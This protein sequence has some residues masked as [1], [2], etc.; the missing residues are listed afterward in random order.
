MLG[1]FLYTIGINIPILT[2][3][4]PREG[5]NAQPVAVGQEYIIIEEYTFFLI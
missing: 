1:Y 3:P 2:K 5:C 4:N